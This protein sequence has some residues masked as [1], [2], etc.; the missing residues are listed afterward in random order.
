MAITI[1][2]LIH[3]T[4]PQYLLIALVNPLTAYLLINAKFPSF[5]LLP[6]VISFAFGILGFNTLNQISD[7]EID[8]IDKPLRPLI[9]KQ[10]GIKEAAILSVIFY[11]LSLLISSTVNLI[12][13]FIMAIFSLITFGY[14]H[15]G[16]YFKKY[17]WGSSFVG[18]IVYGVLPFIAITTISI[19][20][21]NPIF[22][23]FVASLAAITA[24]TKDFEDLP[25]EKHHGI[26][27]LQTALGFDRAAISIVFME[28][29][30]IIIMG[31]FSLYEIIERKF[32]YA[33][34]LSFFL[35]IIVSYLFLR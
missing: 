7:I 17:I 21:F 29:A 22:L 4:T 13:V 12:F 32:V 3:L 35:F 33:S 15:K 1:K 31:I 2:N 9:S 34:I 27:S 23:F 26:R 16:I 20:S 25:G 5:E 24:N 10:M 6:I 8:R 28:G 11:S 19:K 18:A 14:C 30:L